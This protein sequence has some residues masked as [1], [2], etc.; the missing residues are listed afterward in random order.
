MRKFVEG[1]LSSVA[2]SPDDPAKGDPPAPKDGDLEGG[3]DPPAKVEPAAKDAPKPKAGAFAK[4]DAEPDPKDGE[5]DPQDPPDPKAKARP[6]HIEEK[7]WDPKTGEIRVED[8][9]KAYKTL[10]TAHGKLKADK[11]IKG[12]VG[13][14]PEDY[15]PE[16]LVIPEEVKL[17]RI[18]ELDTKNDP[19]VN[20]FRKV[21]HKH[22]LPKDVAA[23]IALDFLSEVNGV[24]PEPVTEAAILKELGDGGAAMRDGLGVWMEG[25]FKAGKWS[26]DELDFAYE[27]FGSSVTGMRLLAKMRADTGEVPIPLGLPS[28]DALPSEAEWYAMHRDP[29]YGKDE[30]YTAKVDALGERI[31]GAEPAGSSRPGAGVIAR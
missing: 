31:F 30:A 2:R 26:A 17:D 5:A 6:D 13:E 25:Q 21:A 15:L 11:G 23:G 24:L 28:G 7:F 1:L 9:A 3:G 14:A 18:R 27:H 8:L 20:A 4:A 12:E 19:A 10:Q 16:G 22:G 29:K